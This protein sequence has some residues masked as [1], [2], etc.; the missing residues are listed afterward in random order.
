MHDA[1]P[2]AAIRFA[3]LL[4]LEPDPGGDAYHPTQDHGPAL[5][6][7]AQADDRLRPGE[8]LT[9]TGPAAALDGRYRF[10]GLACQQGAPIGFAALDASG[11]LFLFAQ[12]APR[13]TVPIILMG[14]AERLCGLR[15][16]TAIRTPNGD[17]L[18]ET[19]APG[20]LVTIESGASAAIL[21]VNRRLA[22][23]LFTDALQAAPVRIPAGALAPRVPARD[24]RVSPDCALLLGQTLVQAG[25]LVGRFG[26]QRKP[27]DGQ[28]ITYL[29][30][31]LPCDALIIAEGTPVECACAPVQD[32]AEP[33]R[34]APGR[35]RAS[36]AR[37]IPS[38]LRGS[39]APGPAGA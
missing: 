10:R 1:P 35:P 33:A 26:I 11:A 34:P 6:A 32:G 8:S 2:P 17:R 27:A 3:Q 38:P 12:T 20:A 13:A 18:I 23:T 7:R 9:I 14:R 21:R 15:P 5:V 22:C 37:Q 36:S 16:G 25:A 30:I 24:I 19:L 29:Q 4:G 31:E 39:L 28:V